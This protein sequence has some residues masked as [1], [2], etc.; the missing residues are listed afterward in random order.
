MS[1]TTQETSEGTV[2]MSGDPIDRG[3]A[4]AIVIGALV[5][6]PVFMAIIAAV[7]MAQWDVGVGPAIGIALWTGIWAG[8]FMG[9]TI[10]VGRWSS[11]NMH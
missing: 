10:V 8:L 3:F 9:G 2:Q 6:I 4:K 1:S 5:G 7:V 11:K